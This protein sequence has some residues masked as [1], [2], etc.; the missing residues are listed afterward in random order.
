MFLPL[1]SQQKRGKQKQAKGAM[2]AAIQDERFIPD[3]IRD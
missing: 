3:L 2:P 1:Q